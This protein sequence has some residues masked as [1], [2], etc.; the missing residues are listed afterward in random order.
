MDLVS[1]LVPV[2]ENLKPTAH[3]IFEKMDLQRWS[4]DLATKKATV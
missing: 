3:F 2:T 4:L 1:K